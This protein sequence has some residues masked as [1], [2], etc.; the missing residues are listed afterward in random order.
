MSEQNFNNQSA[1]YQ[2]RIKGILDSK[3]TA[4]FDGFSIEHNP[5]ETVLTGIVSDQAALHG[6]LTRIRD[7]GLT[8]LCVRRLEN[9]CLDTPKDEEPLRT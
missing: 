9:T 6:I 4:W 2:I 1:Q 3:W 8:I 5:T 7:L